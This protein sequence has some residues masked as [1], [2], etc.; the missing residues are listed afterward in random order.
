MAQQQAHVAG[1]TGTHHMAVDLVR[2][3]PRKVLMVVAN[4][5]VSS[6]NGWP[7]GFWA[8][9]LTHPFYELTERG[10]EVV[11]A[12]PAGGRV[13]FRALS[14]PRPPLPWFSVG[15]RPKG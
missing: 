10:I 3:R 13:E 5:T 1:A 4:P 7:V 8:A 14:S 9:E 6:N 15:L 12:S 11:V 2:S